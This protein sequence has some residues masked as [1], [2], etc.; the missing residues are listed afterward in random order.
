MTPEG[1]DLV[2]DELVLV[3]R[4]QG[5]SNH[6]YVGTIGD[7]QVVYKPIAGEQPLWDFPD[8]RLAYREVAAALISE[9]LGWDVVPPTWF[10][11]GPFGPGMVQ[12]W[13]PADQ[14][15]RP[16]VDI[17]AVGKVPPGYL[18]VF[19][20]TAYDDTPISLVHEDSEL[21][22]RIAIFDVVINNAD[23]KGGH[24]L[25]QPDG[26]RYGIDHGICFHH[27]PK[28]RTVLWGWAGERLTDAELGA[29]RELRAQVAGDLGDELGFWLTTTDLRALAERL[30]TLIGTATMPS[31]ELGRP[32]IPWP[33]F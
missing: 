21:L 11:E 26:H 4:V 29:L 14:D 8:G 17:V 9:A 15:A 13:R 10:R 28:L 3:G 23:R 16:A 25:E 2:E 32:A 20:A 7:Q 18:W 19:D 22:R 5:A 33:P 30:D 12:V 6:T 27:E 24:V 31:P 1:V